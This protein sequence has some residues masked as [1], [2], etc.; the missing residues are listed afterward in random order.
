MEIAA[1]YENIVLGARQKQMDV[2]RAY[3]CPVGYGTI[4]MEE[5]IRRLK[6]HI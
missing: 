3:P 6:A 1:F 4:A 2:F 5:I